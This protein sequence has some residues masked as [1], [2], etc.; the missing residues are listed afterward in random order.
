MTF[1]TAYIDGSLLK[2]NPNSSIAVLA[3]D[4][5]CVNSTMFTSGRVFPIGQPTSI[6][7]DSLTSPDGFAF[8]A[9][10]SLAEQFL[11]GLPSYRNFATINTPSSS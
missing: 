11:F 5:V 8:G 3:H 10:A 1:G 2:G 6:P 7:P 9:G 4:Y